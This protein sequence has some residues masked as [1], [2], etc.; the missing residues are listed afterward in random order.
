M[1]TSTALLARWDA[2]L[3]GNYGTPPLVLDRGVG[4]TVWDVD[5]R[6]YLDLLAG[7]AVSS[8]GHAHP[9]VV[10]AV[11]AQVSRI[12]HTSN[13]AAHEPG[14]VLAERLVALVDAAVGGGS[15]ARVF[16]CNS[17]AE[18]VE[19]A[20]KLVRRHHAGTRTKLVAAT[21]SFHGRTMGALALT[22][23]P[24]KQA[25]FSPF[26]AE[27]VF[28]EYGDVAALEAAVDST[29][30]AVFLE[31]VQGE[32]GVR[33]A[34]GGYLTAARAACDSTGALLVLDEV[35]TGLGRTGT[36]FGFEHDK[37]RPDV[38]TLAKGLGGGLPIGACIGLGPAG[39]A[40]GR[41]DHGSTFGG[42]PVACAAA[43]GVL[44]VLTTS[45]LVGRAAGLG[46]RWATDLA[47]LEHPGLQG[48]RGRGLLLAL[49]LATPVAPEL[50]TAARERGFL[51][52]AVTADAVRLAPPLVLTDAEADTFT[53]ALPELLDAVCGRT[54]VTVTLPVQP[55][56]ASATLAPEAP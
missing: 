55:A 27:V 50:E 18:A 37:I 9:A 38:V 3:M 24:M 25:G 40:L 47:A 28:V 11:S 45:G 32:G 44:G 15:Q 17:G 35:Q 49:Q 1:S 52:N 8:L 51:V 33:P 41:G 29:T 30:A 48:V 34:P 39:V 16:F 23:Q 2:A 46:A 22:G 21:G 12:A 4:S 43:S 31:P 26:P 6:R 20:F 36:W 13:L 56:P 5:G 14:I 54:R 19:A 53:A 10:Q 7:I 42:N